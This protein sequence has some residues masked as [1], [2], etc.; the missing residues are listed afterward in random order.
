MDT[1]T[2]AHTRLTRCWTRV[3]RDGVTDGVDHGL[4]DLT[5]ALLHVETDVCEVSHVPW[6]DVAVVVGHEQL[7]Q[8][9]LV[10][11][12]HVDLGPAVTREISTFQRR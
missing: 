6:V 12:Q 3:T 9:V 5:D 7:V 4:D 8:A 10:A 2:P 11:P 1:A